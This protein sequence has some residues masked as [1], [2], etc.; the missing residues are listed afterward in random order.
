MSQVD[1]RSG[2]PEQVVELVSERENARE[3]RNWMEA[4]NLREQILAHGWQVRDTPEGPVLE[5]KK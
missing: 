5:E 2:P 4:D 3:Q 1:K